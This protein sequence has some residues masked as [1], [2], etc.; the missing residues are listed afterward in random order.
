MLCIA[1]HLHGTI[2]KLSLCLG[3][4]AGNMLG[5]FLRGCCGLAGRWVRGRIASNLKCTQLMLRTLALIVWAAAAGSPPPGKKHT[6]THGACGAEVAHLKSVAL[7]LALP[8]KAGETLAAA[9]QRRS[10]AATACNE[11]SSRSHLVF[12]VA[13]SASSARTGQ[14][15]L[16]AVWYVATSAPLPMLPWLIKEVFCRTAEPG[17][18]GWERALVEEWGHRRQAEGDPGAQHLTAC[19]WTDNCRQ[20]LSDSVSVACMP[21]FL[22]KEGP[23]FVLLDFDQYSATCRPSTRASRRLVRP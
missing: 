8:E 14:K 7:D 2:V 4:R 20:W 12:T 3:I 1:A 16:G 19:H 22:H 17:R 9:M 5:G 6:I 10:V 13:V 23:T 21:C 18:P 15:L 11:R